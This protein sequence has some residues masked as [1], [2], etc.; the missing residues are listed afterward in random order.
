MSSTDIPEGLESILEHNCNQ[1]SIITNNNDIINEEKYLLSNQDNLSI[2][3]HSLFI[4]LLLFF[5]T[6]N[7]DRIDN[8]P[9]ETS[10]SSS[11]KIG[12]KQ[13]SL[14][15]VYD[16]SNDGE[17]TQQQQQQQQS[18]ANSFPLVGIFG[19]SSRS[20]AFTK[21]LLLS[22]FPKPI[23]YDQYSTETDS[24]NL[25]NYVS[26][27]T[28]CHYSPSIILITDHLS[29][30][31]ESF[32]AQNKQQLIIDARELITKYF[33]KNNTSHLLKPISKSYRAFGNISNWEI[34]NGT[35]RTGVAVEQGSPLNLIKFIYD[36][37]CFTRGISYLDSYS[38]DK[39]RIK[40]FRNCLFPFVST[41]IIFSLCFLLS[42]FQHMIN[43]NYSKLIYYQASSITASTSLTL[44]SL[45]FLI[46]PI[47]EIIGFI[48]KT[49]HKRKK[50]SFLLN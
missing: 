37:N 28:F 33:S 20:Q 40:S 19:R 49:Q 8:G 46:R 1:A 30:N 7:L 22:G 13:E 23:L 6:S 47:A 14:I 25:F 4:D 45:L 50:K 17:Q 24:N 9:M 18:S 34:E 43:N 35:Q 29:M 27:E 15:S 21:R 32:I 36:L 5:T 48:S 41:I 44:I 39:E 12:K 2:S 26:Y 31:F 10:I 11:S 42:I 38:Y 3:K 16:N